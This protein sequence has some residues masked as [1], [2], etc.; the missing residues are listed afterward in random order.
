M[1]VAYTGVPGTGKSLHAANDV[2]FAL[3]RKHPRPV[4]ANFELSKDAPVRH[5]EK[6]TYCPNEEMTVQYLIDY[7]TDFWSRRKVFRENYLL[8]VLDE[9]QLWHNS[10]TWRDAS[11][12]DYLKFFSQHRKLGYK[13]ILIAQST[14]MIDNQ[15]RM[16]IEYEVNHRRISSMGPIGDLLAMPFGGRMFLAVEYLYQTN[17][18]V[19]RTVFVARKADMRMYDTR[20]TFPLLAGEKL[21]TT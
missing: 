5:P 2:R 20:V 21:L 4:L 19:G 9:V 15:F 1:I 18:R 3:N 10:R 8:L 14:K 16:E 7:A 17:E 6:F 13:I 12:L 11:R